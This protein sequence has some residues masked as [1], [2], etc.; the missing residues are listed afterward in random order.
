MVLDLPGANRSF[1]ESA[2][3]RSTNSA[4]V[5]ELDDLTAVN[6]IGLGEHGSQISRLQIFGEWLFDATPLSPMYAISNYFS[7]IIG[8]IA[9][10]CSSKFK[11]ENLFECLYNALIRMAEGQFQFGIRPEFI[12]S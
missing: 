1:N 2:K 5:Q 6:S 12:A 4:K 9:E 10:Y 11:F 7:N 3:F 8:E